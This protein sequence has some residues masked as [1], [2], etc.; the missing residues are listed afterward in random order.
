MAASDRQ[1]L[2]AEVKFGLGNRTDV[3]TSVTKWV[4]RAYQ[5]ITQAVD[6]PEGAVSSTIAT[7]VSQRTYALPSNFFAVRSV[8]NETSQVGIVQVGFKEYD[9]F[10]TLEVGSVD[11]Y[12]ILGK[13]AGTFTLGVH[14]VPN[15]IE[16]LLMRYRKLFADLA[17]ATTVHELPDVWDQ[18]IVQLA[19]A[20]GFEALNDLRRAS[21][22]KKQVSGFIA[23]QNQRFAD[24]LLDRNESMAVIGGEIY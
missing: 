18:P 20:F 19:M 1:S 15:T 9:R 8:R 12:T 7:I 10:N 22:Y 14:P 23:S 2:E 6:F 4:R 16:S 24:S 3:D 11:R 21:F 17:T 5:H 13:T